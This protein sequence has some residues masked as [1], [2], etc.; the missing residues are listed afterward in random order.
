HII[1]TR[2][3]C[4]PTSLKLKDNFSIFSYMVAPTPLQN[5]QEISF[6][7]NS[8]L[9]IF[10][11]LQKYF[12]VIGSWCI[13]SCKLCFHG[14]LPLYTLLRFFSFNIMSNFCVFLIAHPQQH[15]KT[16]KE[17]CPI[18]NTMLQKILPL[19]K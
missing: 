1:L 16:S 9:P 19:Q 15:S 11:S 4:A 12:K 13:V 7:L 17:I 3:I 18:L 5:P 14:L 8:M 6:L 2:Y 10:L